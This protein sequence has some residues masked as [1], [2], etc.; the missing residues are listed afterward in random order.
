MLE[1]F[2]NAAKIKQ[3]FDEGKYLK[4][5]VLLAK[6]VAAVAGEFDQ[7]EDGAFVVRAKRTKAADVKQLEKAEEALASI[8]STRPPVGDAPGAGGVWLGLFLQFLPVLLD[9]IRKRREGV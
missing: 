8:Q 6:T 1:L 4:A 2:K 9:L 7:G 5:F 3:L